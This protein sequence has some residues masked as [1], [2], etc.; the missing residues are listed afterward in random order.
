[1]S[2]IPLA[3]EK[4]V[5]ICTR[6]DAVG[7]QKWTREIDSV[8]DGLMIRRSP[9]RKVRSQSEPMT[10]EK[11]QAIRA[12]AEQFPQATQMDIAQVFD[13][14]VGRVSEALAH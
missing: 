11:K 3:R 10:A 4:L 9:R 6:M 12:Y 7:L 13:V 2:N 1:M 14:N 5:D 8:L